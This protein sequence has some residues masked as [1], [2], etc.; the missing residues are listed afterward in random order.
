MARLT[1]RGTTWYGYVYEGGRRVQRTTKCTDKRAAEA[2]VAGWE[3][4]AADPD[5]AA[6]SKATLSGALKLLLD[7]RAEEVGAGRCSE[8]TLAFYKVKGG[9]LLRVLEHD[10]DDRYVP[11]ALTAL[12]TVTVRRYIT[13]RRAEGAKDAT[14]AKELVTLRSALRCAITE[15]LWTGDPKALIPVGFSPDYKPRER[16]LVVSELQALLSKLEADRAARVAF[17]CATGA[18]WSA[19]ERALRSDVDLDRGELLLRGSKNPARWRR[20]PIVGEFFRSLLEYV[21]KWAVGAEGRLFGPW[22][23]PAV[24]LKRACKNSGI[25]VATPNDFRRTYA[26]WLVQAD[27]PNHVVARCLGHK[28]TR[29]V[30]MVYGRQTTDS[31]RDSLARKLDPGCINSASP[32]GRS[33][34]FMAP[35]APMAESPNAGKTAFSVPRDGVEPPTRGFSIPCSTN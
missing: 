8:S 11:L 27:V 7:Q 16:W 4:D 14:I 33:P 25:L 12:K 31:L 30:D 29:M 20:V 17:M 34:A 5:H 24:V 35:M 19:T 1:K 18:E 10:A 26:T 3:R 13:Q 23:S 6:R 2:V 28:S 9:H 22:V 21:L 32:S 15:G